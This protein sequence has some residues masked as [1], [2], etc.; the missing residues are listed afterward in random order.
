MRAKQLR[1]GLLI[2]VLLLVVFWLASS[3]INLLGK[4]RVAVSEAHEAQWQYETLKERKEMLEGNLAALATERGR[5]SAIRTAFGVARAGE[6]V[7]VVV[8]PPPEATT[9]PTWWER[10]VSWF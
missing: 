10:V 7:I 1:Q 5:D 3:I 2:G 8:P 4:A 6:E 9:T